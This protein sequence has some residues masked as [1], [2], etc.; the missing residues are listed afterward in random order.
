MKHSILYD[1]D[2]REV[3]LMLLVWFPADST[4]LCYI[5]WDSETRQNHQ[6]EEIHPPA[7]ASASFHRFVV[8]SFNYHSSHG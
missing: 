1:G 3:F 8:S 7:L 6:L 5:P 4:A 2:T